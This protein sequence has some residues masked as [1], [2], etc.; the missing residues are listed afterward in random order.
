M[1][2]RHPIYLVSHLIFG[3]LSYYYTVLV[4]YIVV[5][6]FIQYIFNVRFFIFEMK[7]KSGNSLE[8]TLIKLS[9]YVA[10]YLFAAILHN[11]NEDA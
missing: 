1:Y 2:S 8:H 11:M 9:E 7:I 6:Q 3:F 10:G 4:Y 5:Y